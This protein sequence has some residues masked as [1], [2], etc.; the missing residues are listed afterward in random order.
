[1]TFN[2]G[3]SGSWND[4][5][6]NGGTGNYFPQG[7]IV[8]Y[9]GMPGD[10]VLNLSAFTQIYIPKITATIAPTPICDSGIAIIEATANTGNVIWFDAATGGNKLGSGSTYTIP[11]PIST[12]TSYYALASSD[13][14]CETGARTKV[15]VVVNTIPTIT[16]V[17]PLT[18]ICGAGIATLTATPSAGIVNWYTTAT[19]ST[20][21]TT[22]NSF[23]TPVTTANTIYY[24][25]ATAN[26]C[27]SLTRTPVYLNV[28]Y[29]LAPTGLST[30]TFCD[31]ENATL[32]DLTITGVN[33]LWYANA[34]SVT[35]LNP[36]ELLVDNNTYYATQTINGCESPTRLAIN[37]S[38]FETV[39]PLPAID[40][41][42]IE[43][44]DT[45]VSGSDTDGFSTFNLTEMRL[46]Y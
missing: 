27:T 31:I 30:Q 17:S 45:T 22:G 18:T 15:E 10:P 40:I 42:I 29:T 20:L 37:V 14:M 5:P 8:E 46:F 36:T 23:T 35:P 7:Y 24:V 4:L 13:G 34:T 39:V 44:C 1:M 41:P 25:D 11:T 38:V 43:E 26:N 32:A 12:T 9:G 33:I 19:G 6:N 2:V 3:K 28:Q 21:I 16:S